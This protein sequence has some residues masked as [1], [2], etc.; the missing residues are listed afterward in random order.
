MAK[1]QDLIAG[2]DNPE[3][4]LR[5]IQQ[6]AVK[7]NIDLSR[8]ALD[9]ALTL[10]VDDWNRVR[11]FIGDRAHSKETQNFKSICELVK[12][13]IEE[14]DAAALIVHLLIAYRVVRAV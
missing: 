10:A 5:V 9:G 11:L 4:A 12:K 7:V 3:E 2:V 1:L 14:K 8:R 13:A 6:E